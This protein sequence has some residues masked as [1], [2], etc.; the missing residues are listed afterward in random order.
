M[1]K[2]EV[3][4][5]FAKNNCLAQLCTQ[6]GW[7]DTDTLQVNITETTP[8]ELSCTVSFEEILMEGSGCVAGRID[9]W[10]DFRISLDRRGEISGVRRA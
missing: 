8:S 10:G 4:E 7:P 5:F 9:C 1:D 3:K 6:N 2:R